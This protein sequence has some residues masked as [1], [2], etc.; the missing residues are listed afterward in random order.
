MERAVKNADTF[1]ERIRQID[2]VPPNISSEREIVR[3]WEQGR[4]QFEYLGPEVVLYRK[5]A[6]RAKRWIERHEHR[7]ASIINIKRSL[8]AQLTEGIRERIEQLNSEWPNDSEIRSLSYL[9]TQTEETIAKEH[10]IQKAVSE[11]C[12]NEA[13][14][15]II[16]ADGV[17]DSWAPEVRRVLS[18]V[19]SWLRD[20]EKA[21]SRGDLDTARSMCLRA[22][23]ACVD[24]KANFRLLQYSTNASPLGLQELESLE[25]DESA[26]LARLPR[27]W[28]KQ[29]MLTAV[30]AAIFL[31]I[32]AAVPLLQPSPYARIEDA[33]ASGDLSDAQRVLS[34]L[35]ESGDVNRAA[36]AKRFLGH[37][38]LHLKLATTAESNE[39]AISEYR[40]AAHFFSLVVQCGDLSH[41]ASQASCFRNIATTQA[42]L[43]E[44][45]QAVTTAKTAGSMYTEAEGYFQRTIEGQD[46]TLSPLMSAMLRHSVDECRRR[47]EQCRHNIEQWEAKESR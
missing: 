42:M 22:S 21:A 36:G 43:G 6:D 45:G 18:D 35:L 44:F 15:L 7:C 34:N 20:A 41:L 13:A 26:L 4:G 47:S 46:G 31:C 16:Q 11:R 29:V 28:H 39:E 5:R 38:N 25:F 40:K 10:A 12:F 19:G 24:S 2:S 33:A 30:T 9:L 23:Q 14:T 1:C 32:V 3:H 27:N 37:A 17:L 8:A